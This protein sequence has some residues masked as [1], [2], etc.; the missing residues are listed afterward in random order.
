MI[1]RNILDSIRS[2]SAKDKKEVAEIM[3]L[4]LKELSIKPKEFA[5]PISAFRAKLSGL[6][7]VVK[8]LKEESKLSF[9]K[10]AQLLNR[11]PNTIWTTYRNAAKKYPQTLD[12]SDYSYSIPA[13]IL[14]DRKFSVLELIVAHLKDNYE[15]SI[16]EIATLLNRNYQTIRTV[17]SRYKTKR[18][19]K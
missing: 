14:K 15:L 8:F 16:N 9:K 10:I 6:E 19:N 12:I 1:V 13:S 4:L 11:K 17:Y 2:Y 3:S 7:I 18:G 5:I